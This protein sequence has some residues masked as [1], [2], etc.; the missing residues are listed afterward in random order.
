MSSLSSVPIPITPLKLLS[1][2]P[3]QW[4][5]AIA[6][7]DKY[8]IRIFE[9]ILFLFLWRPTPKIPNEFLDNVRVFQGLACVKNPSTRRANQW[10]YPPDSDTLAPREQ[11][12]FL[13]DED[14]EPNPNEKNHQD[15]LSNDTETTNLNFDTLSLGPDT[16]VPPST[17]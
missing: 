10:P 15:G 16:T 7:S 6:R 13:P 2:M 17:T 12:K 1:D 3:K 4:T 11:M 5:K 9:S 14:D 8:F